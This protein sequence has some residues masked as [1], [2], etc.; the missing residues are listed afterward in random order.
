M[1]QDSQLEQ[2][3]VGIDQAKAVIELGQSLE[4]LQENKDFVK[5]IN[6]GYLK[7]EAVRLVRLK[8]DPSMQTPESQKRIDDSIMAV[9]QL[10]QYLRFVIQMG[11]QAAVDLADYE[12][13]RQDVLKEV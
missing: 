7:D 1:N 6:E 9:S 10:T 4:R 13:A 11:R 12:E 5:V 8:A 2:I 3:E